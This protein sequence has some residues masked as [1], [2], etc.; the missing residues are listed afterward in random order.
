MERPNII[1]IY[2]DDMGWKDAGFMAS[3]F[4]DTPSIDAL[5]ASGRIFTN[6][7]ANAPNC[8][9]SRAALMTGLYSPRTGIYTV[10]TSKRGKSE[11]R[12]IIPVQ[13]NT[14][15]DTSFVTIAEALK[16]N[17][18]TSISIGKW[19]LGDDP[20]TGP[21]NQGFDFNIGGTHLG[22]PK[23]YFSPYKNPKLS[24][25]P[26]GEYLTDRLTNEA[27]KFI[28]QH[29]DDEFA[30]MTGQQLINVFMDWFKITKQFKIYF[31]SIDFFRKLQ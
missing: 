24:D 30:D 28:D 23:S 14:I 8:A 17:G 27:L 2:A 7:Y 10:G 11:Y 18:Y 5:A 21:L 13:N 19:H 1:F 25:G 12:R 4:Y 9:P 26:E 31:I 6:A 3:E 16:K 22:H 29:K 20:E 15:L